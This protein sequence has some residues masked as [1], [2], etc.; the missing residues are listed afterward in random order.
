LSTILIR[1]FARKGKE[2]LSIPEQH[3]LDGKLSEVGILDA[4]TVTWH[5]LC[6]LSWPLWIDNSLTLKAASDSS[7]ISHQYHTG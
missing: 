7:V 5:S 4:D 1:N 2:K 3:H 6:A